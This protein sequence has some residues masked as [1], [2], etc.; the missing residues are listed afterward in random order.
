MT[1]NGSAGTSMSS[2]AMIST[3]LGAEEVWT[4]KNSTQL[5]HS[6]H[7]HDVPFQLISINGEDPTG[8]QLGWYDTFEVVGGGSLE[9]A[10]KFT[11]FSDDT[12]MY[13]LHCHLLQHEDEGMMA[14]LM[15]TDS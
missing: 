13:M 6:F 7:L 10:M 8:V 2:M 5:E 14:S 15:V 9:I 11:D 4:V 1:I 3:T 12:Y